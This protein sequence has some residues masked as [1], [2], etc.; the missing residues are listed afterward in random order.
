MKTNI[1]LCVKPLGFC[2]T[3]TAHTATAA[4]DFLDVGSNAAYTPL[5]M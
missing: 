2:C 5:P 1:L 4:D 3:T